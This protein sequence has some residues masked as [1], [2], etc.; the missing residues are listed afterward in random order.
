MCTSRASRAV[1]RDESLLIKVK[2][3]GTERCQVHLSASQSIIDHSFYKKFK[4]AGTEQRHVC[5]LPTQ[6]L[7]NSFRYE[8]KPA[9]TEQSHVCRPDS[10]QQHHFLSSSQQELSNAMFV[11]LL[12][13]RPVSLPIFKP[14]GTEQ[15]HVCGPASP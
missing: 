9:G 12:I 15:H 11:S 1:D 7:N 5:L 4:A 10:L 6:P 3:A 13:Y 8:F 14:A 2:A